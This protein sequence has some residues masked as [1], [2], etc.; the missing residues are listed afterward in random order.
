[1]TL[2]PHQKICLLYVALAALWIY[3]SDDLVEKFFSG[4]GEI[5][6]IQHIKGWVYVALSGLCLYVLIDKDIALI[7]K[8]HDQL[9][10]SYEDSMRGWINVMDLRHKETRNHTERVTRA[11]VALAKLAG[12]RGDELINVE[13]GATLH[14]IGKVGIPDAILIKAGPLTAEEFEL[15]KQHPVIAKELI[16]KIDCLRPCIDIPY[17]HHEKWDGSGYPRGLRGLDIPFTARMFAVID[18]WD[19]LS[20]SRVYKDAWSEEKVLDHIRNEAGHHF[21]P[22]IADLF[23]KNFAYL[24]S[25]ALDDK[26]EEVSDVEELLVKSMAAA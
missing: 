1:M 14:D 26:A 8:E 21:D 25:I 9:L 5:T 15:M 19:A 20:Y 17:C 23:L 18:V 13:R 22:E 16:E 7:N 2:K 12:I 3:F 11:A 24:K 10:K 4:A 6:I